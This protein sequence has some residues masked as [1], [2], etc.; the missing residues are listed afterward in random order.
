MEPGIGQDDGALVLQ[1]AAAVRTDLVT[2]AEGMNKASIFR[3]WVSDHADTL[4]RYCQRR[5][6]Q[7][8][9][10]KDLLQETFLA[11]WRTMD[12]YK[13][14]A[15]VKNWLFI[16]LKSKMADHFRKAAVRQSMETAQ[17]EGDYPFFDEDGHWRKGMYPKQ[18]TVELSDAVEA[19]EFQKIL[20]SCCG[21][22]KQLQHSAFLLKYVEGLD[23]EAICRELGLTAANYWVLLHRA[24]VQ[25]R[26]CLEK[27]WIRS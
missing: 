9:L 5:L 16:I 6:Q 26:A 15:S 27:N 18:W 20:Q 25:L 13:G 21:R 2:L 17:R 8:E 3:Q 4:F 1:Q 22:L 11:A 14:E 19:K 24:K 7:E 12:A 23:S 10:C